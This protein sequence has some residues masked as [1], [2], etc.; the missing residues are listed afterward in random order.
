MQKDVIVVDTDPSKWPGLTELFSRKAPG[1]TIS[2]N[3][4][5]TI[6][7]NGENTVVLN[8]D[9]IEFKV[10][11]SSPKAEAAKKSPA[12]RVFKGKSSETTT[13]P[14]DSPADETQEGEA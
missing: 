2:G 9:D 12:A 1:D 14:E 11:K 5:A 8:L 4:T 3:F 7:E 13:P 10:S 6:A